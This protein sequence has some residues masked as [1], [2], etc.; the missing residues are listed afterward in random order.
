MPKKIV[1]D[2][3]NVLFPL[4]YQELEDWLKSTVEVY[5]ASFK[6][7]FDELYVNYEAG[8]F[9]T[10][11]FF[12]ILRTELKMQFDDETFR[13]KW[14]SLWKRDNEDVHELLRELKEKKHSLYLLSNTN[15]MHMGEYLKTRPVLG[16][17]DYTYYSYELQLAK[18]HREIYIKVQSLM[19]VEPDEIVFFDDKPDNVEGAISAGWNAFVYKDV[20]G[21][22]KQLEQ[23][24]CI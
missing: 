22:R 6:K 9:D 2:L 15:E 23:F 13:Q 16:L 14:V 24:K 17:F 11:K 8:D 19:G 20:A 21:V 4:E 10:A 1:F 12:E 3:G 18:P 5:D 7:R